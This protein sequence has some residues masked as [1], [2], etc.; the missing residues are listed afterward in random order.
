MYRS[1]QIWNNDWFSKGIWGGL[2]YFGLQL[3]PRDAENILC[4]LNRLLFSENLTSP[5]LATPFLIF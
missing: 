5:G 1:V 2:P 3:E 4:A